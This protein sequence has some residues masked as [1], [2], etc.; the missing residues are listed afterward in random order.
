[1]D[2]SI[3]SKFRNRKCPKHP[4]SRFEKICT[5]QE[6]INS[7]STCLLCYQCFTI[8]RDKHDSKL[9]Y[10]DFVRVFSEEIIKEVEDLA[11]TSAETLQ[12]NAESY[13]SKID[14]YC[15]LILIE[16]TK[17]L[18]AFKAR[19][20]LNYSSDESKQKFNNFK[21]T[22]LN[23]YKILFSKDEKGIINEDIIRYLSFF[24]S[25]DKNLQEEKKK[26]EC[27]LLNPSKQLADI[28]EMLN[29]KLYAVK[30]LLKEDFSIE[31]KKVCHWNWDSNRKSSK[32]LITDNKMKATK[33]I[34]NSWTAIS[35]NI[36]MSEGIQKWEVTVNCSNTQDLSGLIFGIIDSDII[37]NYEKFDM[38]SSLGIGCSGLIYSKGFLLQ[39]SNKKSLPNNS[40]CLCELDLIQ[41]IFKISENETILFE[42]HGLKEKKFLPFTALRYQGNSVSIKIID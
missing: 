36:I 11:E 8:H 22:L 2:S 7:S 3:S 21:E 24:N 18:E 23:E 1:M 34:S 20:K 14:E 12:S 29:N 10:H 42:I 9:Q 4:L 35:G 26:F 41:G 33:D 39:N 17:G 16:L 40:K 37:Y 30:D 15:S 38:Q 13:N 5:S 19:V 27:M 32:I 6:C 31:N 28:S 25:F